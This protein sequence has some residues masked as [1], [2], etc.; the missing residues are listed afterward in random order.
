M[1][2]SYTLHRYPYNISNPN[3]IDKEQALRLLTDFF[4]NGCR[5]GRSKKSCLKNAIKFIYF[6]SEATSHCEF[7]FPIDR[8]VFL[9][10]SNGG[11]K[12]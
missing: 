4:Y 3:S 9:T 5:Y 12:R 10:V 8:N 11:I 2:I 7:N 6:V 1:T